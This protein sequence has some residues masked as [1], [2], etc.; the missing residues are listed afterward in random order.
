[1]RI[2]A[3]SGPGRGG[4]AWPDEARR[5]VE[6]WNGAL[7][8]GKG[9]W[10]WSPTIRAAVVAGMPWMDVYCPGC[11]TSRAI[12][13]RTIDRHPLASVEI[14]GDIMRVSTTVY[15]RRAVGTSSGPQS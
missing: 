14:S 9:V 12:D 10:W 5:V 11:R 6:L 8:T 1:L 15:E 7:A 3:R 2:C 4:G 13:I